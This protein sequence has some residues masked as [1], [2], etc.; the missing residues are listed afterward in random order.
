MTAP[1]TTQLNVADLDY[2]KI[3]AN[4]AAFMQQYSN[5]TDYNYQGSGL[6]FLLDVLAY[7]T[8]YNAVLA[9]MQMN[10][11]YLDTAVKRASVL[12][13][14]KALGSHPAGFT[15]ARASI[16]LSVTV[17]TNPPGS[18]LIKRG[19]NF[20]APIGSTS[21]NFVTVADATASRDGNTYTFNDLEL[22][23]G[24]LYTNYF[25]V[26]IADQNIKYT[27][28]NI[29]PD[30]STIVM[31]VFE[32]GATAVPTF[33]YST[34]TL[35]NLTL[36]S[37]VFFTQEN[38]MGQTEFYFGNGIVGY[39]PPVGSIVQVGYVCCNGVAG[40]GASIFTPAG[41]ITDSSSTSTGI[42]PVV[43]V[44]Q[45]S[46]GGADAESIDQIKFNAMN[47]F[48]VQNRA[49]TVSDYQ[50][51]IT[52]N[53]TNIESLRVWGGEDNVPVYYNSVLISAK[54]A[55]SDVLTQVEK[56]NISAF[57]APKSI[58]GMRILFLDPDYIYLKVASTVYYQPT[59]VQV[60]TNLQAIAA[61]AIQAYS[62]S[63]LESFGDS[64]RYSRFVNAI[65]TSHP[66]F[67]SNDTTVTM[68]KILD[69]QLNKT[70][71]YTVSF[72]NP[73]STVQGSVSSD[74][75]YT[76][77]SS[78][79]LT[80]LNI[81]SSL[82]VGYLSAG[83][84]ITVAQVGSV[85]YVNGILSLAPLNIISIPNSAD[86]NIYAVPAANDLNSSQNNIIEILPQDVTVITIPETSI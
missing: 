14:A 77:L 2:A 24:I 78:L 60:N 52:E 43:T 21:Y 18:F 35:L 83:N 20:T 68:Y 27:L 65:D 11:A 66:S 5:F 64:F 76:T 15:G 8:H 53:F 6:S 7:N 62:A 84:F 13:H 63:N 51:L 4:L 71:L 69:T 57:L 40:N 26:L 31:Q 75:F 39:Q 9:N 34:D 72:L 33:Y 67:L 74:L 55:G 37:R 44:N 59:L 56:N 19:M 10:E 49:V 61:A 36:T 30:V 85:D 82:V 12:S 70:V 1:N 81:G 45:T 80:L 86:L 73:I 46:F 29:Q 22:V 41:T 3:R 54:P 38:S 28:P 79:P 47:H 32:G 16:N 23:E 48:P 17:A 50:S 42:N 25:N 58:M